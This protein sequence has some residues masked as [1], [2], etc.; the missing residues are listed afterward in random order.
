MKATAPMLGLDP[1]AVARLPVSTLPGLLAA[2]A[3]LTTAVAARLAA[4]PAGEGPPNVPGEDRLVTAAEATRLTG[5]S[6]RWLYAHADELPFACRIGR[7]VR[8]S[9][10]GA[11]KWVAARQGS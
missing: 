11:L 4:T 7:A 6:L 3:A 10:V 2:L 8:F 1:D 9:R 5:M